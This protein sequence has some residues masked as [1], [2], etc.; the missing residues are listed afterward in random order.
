[1]LDLIAIVT[2]AGIVIGA[3]QLSG[4]TSKLPIL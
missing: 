2:L 3:L 1:M 4:F